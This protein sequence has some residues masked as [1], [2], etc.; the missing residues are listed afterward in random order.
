[1][2]VLNTHI[3][4]SFFL[5]A[6]RVTF[7]NMLGLRTPMFA[8]IRRARAQLCLLA[9]QMCD[10]RIAIPITNDFKN[11]FAFA[12]EPINASTYTLATFKHIENNQME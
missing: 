4:L 10:F 3:W 12:A 6:E 1:M 8:R 9:K 7:A 2:L 11:N 5:T